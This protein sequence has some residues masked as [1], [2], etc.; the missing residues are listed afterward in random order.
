LNRLPYQIVV[1][2]KEM[3]AGVVAVRPRGG[4]DLGE[5]SLEMLIRR[6]HEEVAARS[7]T[8]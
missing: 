6:L 1:G 4:L 2:D 7:G 8:A 5:M 3:A